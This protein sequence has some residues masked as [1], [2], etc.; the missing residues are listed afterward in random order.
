MEISSLSQSLNLCSRINEISEIHSSN[1]NEVESE[2]LSSDSKKLL[3]D[4]TSHFE[5]KVKQIVEEYSDLGFLGI[6]DLNKYLAHLKEALNQV[7]AESTQISKE[8]EDLS[9]NHIEETNILE[10]N[11][12]GLKCALDSIASQG[13]ETVER[14]PAIKIN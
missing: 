8:I 12:D 10:G 13:L 1:K 5:S 3:K 7:E 2:A 6:E 14:T 11:L 9:R 4:C